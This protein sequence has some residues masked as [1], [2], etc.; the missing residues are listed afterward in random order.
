MQVLK[1]QVN[2]HMKFVSYQDLSVAHAVLRLVNRS[3]NFS[4]IA[5]YPFVTACKFDNISSYSRLYNS[6]GSKACR[7]QL[8]HP[9]LM[10]IIFEHYKQLTKISSKRISDQRL[11]PV[12]KQ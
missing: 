12:D 5:K 4:G 11:A 8:M 3:E 1:Y 7:P 9:I 10:W 2:H 6:A